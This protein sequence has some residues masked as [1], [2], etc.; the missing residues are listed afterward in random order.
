[1]GKIITFGT[2]KGGTGKTTVVFNTVGI[3]ASRGYNVLV[4]D[5]DPQANITSDL[6]VDETVPE[7]KGIKEVFEND[8]IN[9]EE[10][11]TKAPLTNF[12]TLDI[13]GACMGLTSTELRVASV[14][15]REFLIKKKFKKNKEILDRYDYI[16]FDTNPSMSVIN[17]NSFVVSDAIV[18]VSDVGVNALKGIELFIAL[19]QDISSRLDIDDNIKGLLVNKLDYSKNISKEFMEYCTEEED[20]RKII[21]NNNIAFNEKLPEAELE[22]K[23]VNILFSNEEICNQF[24]L[25]VDELVERVQ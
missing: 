15:A 6:C 8:N 1:M 9:I 5:I 2:L 14:P 24:N 16:I 22:R 13:M 20:L 21:F 18:L 11:I 17:Q 25:F 3:L 23:P 7:Y 12:P 19:W 4:V 10:A